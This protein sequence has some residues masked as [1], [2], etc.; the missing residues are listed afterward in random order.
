MSNIKISSPFFSKF[1]H[2]EVTAGTTI[3]SVLTAVNPGEKRILLVIQNQ[4]ANVITVILNGDIAVT[5]GITVQPDQL[6]SF[7]NYSGPLRIKADGA[8][9]LVHVAH[10][11]V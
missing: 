3:S 1:T 11:N 7:D 10:A 4:S 8:G 2:Q 6:V 9:S 5:S